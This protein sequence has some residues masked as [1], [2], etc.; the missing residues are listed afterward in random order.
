MAQRRGAAPA[1]RPRP[2]LVRSARPPDGPRP[3]PRA[4]GTVVHAAARRSRRDGHQGRA[5]RRRRRH[6]RVGAAVSQGRAG[7][8]HERGR[9]LP[10]RAT[11]ASFR[12]PSTSPRPTGR[13]SCATSRDSADVLVE[14]YKVGGLAK[15]GLDYASLAAVNPRLVYCSITG[16]GQD[17]PYADRAGYDF[18]I[19]GMGGLHERHRRARRAA[20]RRPAEGG[21]RDHRPD[22]RHVRDGR[23]P[24]GARASRSDRAGAVDRRLPVRL[25][26]RDDGDDVAQL[27]R[28]R[29]AADARRQ[30]APEHRAVP[31]VRRAPTAT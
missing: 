14:N 26:G 13:R 17:G 22:D 23:D 4:R 11:A 29:H 25:R 31:G 3:V 2:S 15:Y 16:F 5:P 20:R 27:S 6:A 28:H 24:G 30:R 1:N 21:R 12:S 7:P 9:V 8:R 19:Q 18:I 10:L